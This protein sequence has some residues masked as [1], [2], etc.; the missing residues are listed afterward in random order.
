MNE[1][2]LVRI[3]VLVLIWSKVGACLYGA[4]SEEMERVEQSGAEQDTD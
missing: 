4:A 3:L 2:E 1:A